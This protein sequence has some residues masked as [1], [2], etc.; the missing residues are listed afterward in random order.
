MSL[1]I[2]FAVEDLIS[3]RSIRVMVIDDDSEAAEL[4]SLLLQGMGLEPMVVT[5]PASAIE[6]ALE[7][8]PHVAIIDIEMPKVSG[9][10]LALMFRKHS[11]LGHVGL[12]ALSGWTDA[13]I[14]Q[15]CREFGFDRFFAKPTPF[16]QICFA[17]VDYG[18]PID[19]TK[20]AQ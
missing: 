4:L 2:P 17:L 18:T 16:D 14:I 12:F 11:R 7:F 8:M 6:Q 13:A 5:D 19:Q 20:L 3:H 9:W 15:R 10:E 1:S